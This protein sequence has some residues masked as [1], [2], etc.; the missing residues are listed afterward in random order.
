MRTESGE[1]LVPTFSYAN[2]LET[3]PFFER[4]SELQ[5]AIAR[6]AYEL[7]AS[8]GF[9][10]GRDL[11]HWLQA[12]SEILQPAPLDVTETENGFR[13]RAEVPG[14]REGEI[15]VR[16]EPR[17][18]Y[19]SGE[20]KEEPEGKKG[21]TIYSE[22]GSKSFATLSACNGMAILQES[23]LRWKSVT[24]TAPALAGPPTAAAW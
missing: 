4:L 6:R 11:E 21:K 17:R 9:T 12:E 2:L 10:D 22:R 19:I 24:C 16:A 5:E 15:E 1:E 13:V 8:N 14:F 3:D 20:R 7:F 18:I 23:R